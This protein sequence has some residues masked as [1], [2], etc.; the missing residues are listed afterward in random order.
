MPIWPGW[1]RSAT[2]LVTDPGG[3]VWSVIAVTFPYAGV[4]LS[5]FVV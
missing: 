4:A 1:A 3:P 5:S 2:C